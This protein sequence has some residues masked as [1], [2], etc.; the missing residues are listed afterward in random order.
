MGLNIAFSRGGREFV[1]I[2]STKW[3]SFTVMT[4]LLQT[5]C[6]KIMGTCEIRNS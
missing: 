2:K 6:M 1:N 5:F 4:P 3:A